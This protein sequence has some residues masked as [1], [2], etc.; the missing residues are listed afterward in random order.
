MPF[1]LR[2]QRADNGLI[3]RI[4]RA[5]EWNLPLQTEARV[6]LDQTRGIRPGFH[7]EHGIG[8]ERRNLPEVRTEIRRIQWM[9]ELPHNRAAAF[10][11]S[12]REA[13]HCSW[14]NV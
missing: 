7:R 6:L 4:L 14:P 10:G 2:P 9:P 8:L 12:L 11:E 1:A 13:P 5:K 3:R